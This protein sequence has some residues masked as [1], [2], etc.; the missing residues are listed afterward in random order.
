MLTIRTSKF[1]TTI[2]IKEPSSALYSLAYNSKGWFIGNSSLIGLWKSSPLVIRQ[3]S[4]L[5]LPLQ[6]T[7]PPVSLPFP[8]HP[9]PSP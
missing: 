9:Q 8:A 5:L 3:V 6:L 4:G 7:F 1:N 2:T